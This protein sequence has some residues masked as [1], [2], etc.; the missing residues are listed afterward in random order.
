MT[1]FCNDLNYRSITNAST[2]ILKLSF[3]LTVK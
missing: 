1:A 2:D 3:G